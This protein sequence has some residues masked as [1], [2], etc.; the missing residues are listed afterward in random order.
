MQN[1]KKYCSGSALQGNQV[2]VFSYAFVLLLMFLPGC[3]SMMDG[4]TQAVRFETSGDSDVI[5]IIQDETT[6]KIK[7]PGTV[8]ID[9]G[10][11]GFSYRCNSGNMIKVPAR[12]NYTSAGNLCMLGC[13]W[14]GLATDGLTG[15]V[16]SYPE[17]ITLGQEQCR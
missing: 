13:F 2:N 17:T 9:R 16:W 7:A 3:A 11:G 10:Y 15:A 6:L 1:C 5:S 14:V 4:R 8:V 12:L